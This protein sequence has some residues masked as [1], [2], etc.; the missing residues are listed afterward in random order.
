MLGHPKYEAI[1]DS[2]SATCENLFDLPE[3]IEGLLQSYKYD[4]AGLIIFIA[5]LIKGS[6]PID[7]YSVMLGKS[8]RH[9]SGRNHLTHDQKIRDDFDKLADYTVMRINEECR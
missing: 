5:S 4:E 3:K 9:S 1:P 2:M 8:G 6:V 7:L